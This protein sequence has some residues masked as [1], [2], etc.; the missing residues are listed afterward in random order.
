MLSTI[1]IMIGLSLILT[2]AGCS[3]GN[4]EI[5]GDNQS[6][7]QTRSTEAHNTSKTSSNNDDR[8]TSFENHVKKIK[9]SDNIKSIDWS[10]ET[11]RYVYIKESDAD[12]FEVYYGDF[13]QNKEQLV[14]KHNYS[15]SDSTVSISP[16][17]NYF[18]LT[19]LKDQN[20]ERY[21]SK[22][23]FAED[24][25]SSMTLFSIGLPIWDKEG[26]LIRSTEY[27]DK[28]PTS[29]QS[30]IS[31]DTFKS[32]PESNDPFEKTI[33][34]VKG[35]PYNKT[36]VIFNIVKVKNNLISYEEINLETKETQ[37]KEMKY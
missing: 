11:E 5:S 31:V 18:L 2:M 24:L 10:N 23:Y 4:K 35:K 19:R 8:I 22:L 29:Y 20:P 13:K 14:V 28:Y 3:E 36:K 7:S 30:L 27:I 37:Q 17:G 33:D 1:K 16:K 34:V 25:Q 15:S 6:P 26:K 12:K 32:K 21:N 9:G